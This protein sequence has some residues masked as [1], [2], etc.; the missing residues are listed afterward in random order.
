MFDYQEFEYAVEKLKEMISTNAYSNMHSGLQKMVD[1]FE[2]VLLNKEKSKYFK[3]I[4]PYNVEVKRGSQIRVVNIEPQIVE[5]L[6]KEIEYCGVKMPLLVAEAQTNNGLYELLNGN[7]RHEAC[8][9]SLQKN[10]QI[11]TA[12]YE[13][14]CVVIDKSDRSI[15][16]DVWQYAQIFLNHVNTKVGNDENDIITVLQN[17]ARDN[18]L[19]L[20]NQSDKES[21]VKLC[22]LLSGKHGERG[23]KNVVTRVK[24]NIKLTNSSIIQNSPET[25]VENF[26]D[27]YKL[28]EVKKSKGKKSKGDN[29]KT[30]DGTFFN[31]KF[32]GCVEFVS[33]VGSSFDQRFLRDMRW[34]KTNSNK[35]QIFILSAQKTS[36]SV[37]MVLSQR[38]EFF[39]KMFELFKEFGSKGI[40]CDYVVVDAQIRNNI[41][42]IEIDGNFYDLKA[43]NI[44][45]YKIITKNE[46]IKTFSS[47]RRIYELDW[48]FTEDKASN[49]KLVASM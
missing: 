34:S 30:Y 18:N 11:L 40:W 15:T 45:T 5:K 19:D 32:E 17:H 31:K 22:I 23:A 13:Y 8:L 33:M 14:P 47:N 36:G 4:S 6:R 41:S 9:K 48:I 24:N 7:H 21:L 10:S 42:N 3:T 39:S 29:R 2:D 49:L 12:N 25:A 37:N 20:N 1:I 46:I 16:A 44:H 26:V 27:K 28:T 35:S 38:K 43:E